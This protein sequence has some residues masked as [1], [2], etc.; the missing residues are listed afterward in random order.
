MQ[1]AFLFTGQ[2][3]QFAGMGRELA[4]R[5]PA[6]REVFA[7]ADEALGQPLSQMCF[8]GPDAELALTANTQPATL[9]VA[10]A[11]YRALGRRPHVAAGHSLG[12]YA[13][14]VAAEAFELGDAVRLVR[15]RARRMQEAVPVGVGGMVVLRKMTLDDA[16]RLVAGVT[17]GVC[18]IANVNA[19]GQ[20]V[21]SGETAGMR[22]LMQLAPPKAALELPVSVPFHCSLL[23]DA[24]AGFADV[25]AA[26]PMRDPAFPVWCNV[27]AKPVTTAAA[28]RD[29]LRRQFAG[30]VLWQASLEGMLQAGVRR[31]V[32]FGPKAPLVKMAIQTAN[33]LS[34]EGVATHAATTPEEIEAV[35]ALDME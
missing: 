24:A 23:Q 8:S 20:V 28:A 17:D 22:Q 14:L 16:K 10:T 21:V 35:R 33:H 6:A 25:L 9:A 7:I 30:A 19:P 4:E 32:E 34:I 1:T 11:A 15:E 13:A 3:S 26:V 12:E 18:E 31:F 29:A 2:G 5:Y 27:D